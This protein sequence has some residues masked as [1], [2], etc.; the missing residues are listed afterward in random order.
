M[1]MIGYFLALTGEKVDELLGDPAGVSA[2]LASAIE[3][4]DDLGADFLD[5]DKSWHGIHFLL[6]G[7]VR[8]GE[9]PLTWAVFAPTPIG[10]DLGHGPARLLLPVQVVE[11][12]KA[13]APMTGDKLKKKCDWTVM[14]DSEIYPQG[15][16][17][18]DQ[19]YIAENFT[20]LR[21]FYDSAARRHMAVVHWLG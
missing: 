5:V 7:S 9:P 8:D 3:D 21:K 6:T 12:S 20:Q 15:W 13:L 14:N 11:V 18:G 17:A 10:E 16:R 1:S 2:F 19:D 4:Q